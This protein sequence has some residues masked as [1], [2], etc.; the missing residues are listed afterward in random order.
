M[1]EAVFQ[2][3]Q[4]LAWGPNGELYVADTGNHSIRKITADGVTTIAGDG[5]IGSSDGVGSS[6]RFY[7]PSGL[8]VDP[9]GTIYVADTL[10]HVIR[11][12]TPDGMVTTLSAASDRLVELHPGYVERAGDYQDGKLSEASST[13]QRD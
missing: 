7:A 11:R 13:S 3:P 10:N 5:I 2:S 8:V 6:A 9:T 12:I 1:E 4:A